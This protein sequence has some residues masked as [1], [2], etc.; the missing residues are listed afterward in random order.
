MTG[1]TRR[2]LAERAGFDPGEIESYEVGADAVVA[3]RL[4]EIAA[5]LNVP[6]AYFFEGA[7]DAEQA[8][9]V[10]TAGPDDEAVELVR[11][12]YAIPEDRRRRLWDLA[13]M[14]RSA[15]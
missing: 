4:W 5:A 9:T 7:A 3:S 12:Y 11:A 6:V 1:L 13:R 15:A 10:T 2:E 14:L 8:R